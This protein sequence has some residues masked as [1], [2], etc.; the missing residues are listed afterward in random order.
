MSERNRHAASHRA[1]SSLSTESAGRGRARWLGSVVFGI[2]G[3]LLAS[4]L[5]GTSAMP[6]ARDS[7]DNRA[8]P[9]AAAPAQTTVREVRYTDNP[10]AQAR[11]GELEQRVAAAEASATRSLP[12]EETADRDVEGKKLIYRQRHEA[13]VAKHASEPVDKRW[14]QSAARVLGAD[15]GRLEAKAKFRTV[16]MD[17]RSKSCVGVLEWPSYEQALAAQFSVVSQFYGMNCAREIYI[18][19]PAK[20]E[21]RYQAKLVF[22]CGPGAR[23]ANENADSAQANATQSRETIPS[24]VREP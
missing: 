21:D 20:N 13:A 15:L 8:G 5:N 9:A 1:V 11:L 10:A 7:Q 17:C 3:G 16:E 24:S 22:D 23:K 12:R 14:A 4:F 2:G 19:E 18:P 6:R